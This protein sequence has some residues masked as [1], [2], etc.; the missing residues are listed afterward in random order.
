MKHMFKCLEYATAKPN[1]SIIRHFFGLLAKPPT[2]SLS[3]LRQVRLLKGKHVH[4][5]IFL[6]ATPTSKHP[7]ISAAIQRARD[8]YTQV[9]FG[10]ARVIYYTI[11]A[12]VSRGRENL[13]NNAEAKALTHEWTASESLPRTIDVFFVLSWG[14]TTT[15]GLA[16]VGGPCDKG[17]AC[18]MNGAVILLSDP[19]GMK[20][21][22]TLAHELGH[23]LSLPH[24]LDLTLCTHLMDEVSWWIDLSKEKA[25]WNLQQPAFIQRLMFPRI[26]IESDI[27][28]TGD[29]ANAI[30]G[31][32]STSDGC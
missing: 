5:N 15:L 26:G 28:M 9:N 6:V 21:G 23:F 1:I 2:Y 25:C 27:V 24:A 32:C 11:S 30:R 13:N 19:K 22:K 14:A 20:T 8:I 31:H 3:L 29:E 16:P 17:D 7:E 4:L 12:A 10:I 18:I